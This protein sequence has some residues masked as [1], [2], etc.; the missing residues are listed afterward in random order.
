MVKTTLSIEGMKCK[1]CEAHVNDLIKEKYDVKKVESSAK[2]K[3]TVV[4]SENELDTEALKG[5]IAELG[6]TM[7]GSQTEPYKKGLFK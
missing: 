4:I 2:D 6:F 1:M 5:Q 7:T 3:R